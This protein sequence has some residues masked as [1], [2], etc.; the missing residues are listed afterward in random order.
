LARELAAHT[1]ESLT[2]AVIAAL[3]ERLVREKGSSRGNRLSLLDASA[4]PVISRLTAW[5]AESAIFNP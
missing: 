5:R 1:G 3:R 4:A 2:A